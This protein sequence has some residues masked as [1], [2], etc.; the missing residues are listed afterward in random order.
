MVPLTPACGRLQV[1]FAGTMSLDKIAVAPRPAP[2]WCL[3]S[4]PH[5]NGSCS[6]DL[7]DKSSKNSGPWTVLS[8]GVQSSSTC[9]TAHVALETCSQEA[10]LEVWT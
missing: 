5:V 4:Y 1:I 9:A 8:T 6:P 3:G 10:A 7:P 2:L